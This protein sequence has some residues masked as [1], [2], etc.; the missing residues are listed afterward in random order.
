MTVTSSL[1]RVSYSG[2]GATVLFTVPFYFLENSHIKVVLTLSSGT[3]T[4]LVLNTDY[5]VSGAG[6][7]SGGTITCVT[8][9]PTGSTLVIA[10]N[11]P[12][13][14]ETDY[15]P[16]DPFPAQTHERALDKLTMI[17]QQ[18]A[19]VGLRALTYPITDSGSLSSE[20]PSSGD[21]ANQYLAFDNLGQ[22]TLGGA[23]PAQIYLGAKAVAPTLRNDGTALAQGDLYFNSALLKMQVYSGTAWVDVG[24]P[25][26]LTI[27]LDQFSGNA[28]TTVFTLS[29]AP[30]F[31]NATE[32][33]IA[34]VA[35]K[36][37]SDY[38][39]VGTSLTFASAPP[40]GTNNIM[41]RGLSS[42]TGGVPNDGSVGTSKVVDGA[43]TI[44][45]W[46]GAG[47]ELGANLIINGNMLFDQRNSNGLVSGVG[48]A[49]YLADRW[50]NDRSNAGAVSAQ[51]VTD[52]PALTFQGVPG[53]TYSLKK[54]VTTADSSVGATDYEELSQ[55]I[56]GYFV[57]DLLYQTFTLSFWVKA[58]IAGLYCVG[59][60]NAGAD[61][62]YI[63]EY[64]INAANTW[65]RKTVT[66]VGGIPGTGTWNYTN[67]IGMWVQF[68]Q[69]VGSNFRTGTVGSW[70][71]G[72]YIASTNA[73]LV[74]LMGTLNATYQ[75]TGVQLEFGAQATP[76]KFR[77]FP[78]EYLLCARY[79]E[80]GVYSQTLPISN[81]S[82]TASYLTPV[83]WKQYKRA[84]P[85]VTGVNDQGTHSA[86][87]IGATAAAIGRSNVVANR[88][89]TGTYVADAEL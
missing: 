81:A 53:I 24:T 7:V 42:Y 29:V 38:T 20:L 36:P 11:V 75:I 67:G 64:T 57:R 70:V 17:A 44:A 71:T 58:S 28:S 10:R 51:V 73:A 16:N 37:G 60:T 65:E 79:Y 33:Y 48:T 35:Q 6:V 56:E 80:T 89:N 88:I 77:P 82:V 19:D 5:T 12:V 49:Q 31:Q 43:I 66:V 86:G 30:A 47:I 54:T 69:M 46:S 68:P 39:V 78:L 61:R 50:R 18:S 63:A 32:V 25:I 1:S 62:S 23:I 26:P 59:L 84:T 45:K 27:T 87:S 21:R 15:Q 85:T 76:F 4:T 13:T 9:P 83:Y 34:G 41:V 40:T 2:N 8:A 14:Q 22:P 52:S 3:V 72:N 74:N 55:C